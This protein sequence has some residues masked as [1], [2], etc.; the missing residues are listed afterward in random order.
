MIKAAYTMDGMFVLY[1]N[2]LWV[3]VETTLV[4]HSFISV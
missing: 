3:P 2:T 1:N 4:G